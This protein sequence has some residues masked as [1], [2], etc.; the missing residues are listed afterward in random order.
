MKVLI[1]GANGQLGWELQRTVPNEISVLALN[2]K[3]LD[4]TNQASVDHS[5]QKFQP[6]VLINTAAYTAV[7]NA[8]KEQEKAFAVNATGAGIVAEV[9]HNYGVRIIQI[10]TDFIFDGKKSSPYLPEDTPNPLGVYG[11]SKLAGE[12][13]VNEASQNNALVLRTG[14]VYSAHGHNFVK[15]MLRL[16]NERDEINVVADQVGTPTWAKGLAE[17]IWKFVELPELKGTYHWTDAGVA[18]WY[19]FAELINSEAF[20]LGILGQRISIHPIRTE[21]YKTA[22][23]RPAYSVMDKTRT[24]SDIQLQSTHWH[25]AMQEMLSEMNDA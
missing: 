14:W 9:A 6:D 11:A 17:A 2:S 25:T 22:A 13:K 19:D 20:N 24:W 21:E 3:Q 1:T 4:I 18:S 5:I 23:T 10:S 12:Q 7:D 16:M 15:T 8:E